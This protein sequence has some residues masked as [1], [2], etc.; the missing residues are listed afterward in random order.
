MKSFE[1]YFVM[2][3][4]LTTKDRD[5]LS[6]DDYGI[7]IKDKDGNV[8]E[9]AYPMP[10]ADH[11]KAAVRMF[12]HADS[13]YKK[14]LA[15]RIL[16]KARK[17]NLDTSGWDSLKEYQESFIYEE[18]VNEFNQFCLPIRTQIFNDLLT[19]SEHVDDSLGETIIPLYMLNRLRL[20]DVITLFDPARIESFT[21]LYRLSS[22]VSL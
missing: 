18:F 6:D 15:K 12:P 14:A 8:T 7:I 13:K 9:R 22:A 1:E 16:S 17:Y 20:V 19:C 21:S 4:K 11:V 2:E 3:E 10:D 5:K